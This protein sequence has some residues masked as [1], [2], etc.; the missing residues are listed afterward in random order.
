MYTNPPIFVTTYNPAIN[1][2]DLHRALNKHW[3]LIEGNKQLTE[4]FPKPPIIAFRRDQNI[5]ENLVRAKLPQLNPNSNSLPKDS[6]FFEETLEQDETLNILLSLLEEQTVPYNSE[7][8]TYNT[9]AER[10]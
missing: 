6:G 3:F 1:H 10:H 9:S 5:R 2:R 4:K 8:A 7:R